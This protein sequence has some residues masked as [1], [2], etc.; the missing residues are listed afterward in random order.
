MPAAKRSRP[1]AKKPARRKRT[2]ADTRRRS[3]RRRWLLGGG[4][5]LLV[6]VAWLVWPFWQLSGQFAD[7]PSLQPSRLYA[8]A[9]LLRVGGPGS[10]RQLVA[11]L[12][13]LG[14][15]RSTD[16][17][18]EAGQ[19]DVGG[20]RVRTHLRAFPT[21]YGRNLGGPLEVRFS[22]RGVARL[23]W[24]GSDVQQVYL[25]P[26]LLA[27]Y[28]GPDRKE[29]RPA[30]L[31]ALPPHLV[32]AVLAAEDA[33]FYRHVGLS[34]RGIARAAWVNLR[35][36]ELR[37]GGSTLTQQLVKN[38]FL[39]HER[40]LARKLREIALALLVDL[41]YD[42]DAI[43]SA[44]LN[45]IYW[46]ASRSINLMGVGAAAWA[47][48]GK[49][50]RDLTV[51]ESAVLAGMI[52]SPGD[53]SPVTQPAA[54][55]ARRDWVLGRMAELEWLESSRLEEERARPLCV[56]PRYLGPR[57]AAYFADVAAGEARQRFGVGGLADAGYVLLS[58][59]RGADQRAAEEAAA[60]GIE[61]LE[62]GWEKGRE[63]SGPLQAA[64]VSIDPTSGGIRAYVGGRDY[65]ASQ[66]DRASR[67][68]RQAGSA[69]KPLVYAA[70][71]EHGVATPGTLL[72]D[73]P[74]TVA[75]AGDDWTPRNSD[76]GF[77]GW[78]TARTAVEESLN[79]P[80]A[81]LAL[82]VGL[83][84]V[85][86]LAHKLGIES[87]LRAV[88]ALA[89]GAFEVTPIELA[90]VYATLAAGGVRRPVHG[91]EAVL[92]PDGA[93]VEGRPLAAAERVLTPQTAYIVTSV[94]QGVLERGTGESARIQGVT[95][96]LAGKTGTTNDRRDSWFAGFSPDRTTLVWVGY[97]DNSSSRLSG[98]RAAL[99]IWGRFT[100]AVRPSNGYPRFVP[101]AGVS[102]A[103]IDPLSGQLATELCPRIQTEVF[104]E[105]QIPNS[106][107]YLH[108]GWARDQE[109]RHLREREIR[110]ERRR[111]RW[112]KRIFGRKRGG[113]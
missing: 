35:G 107:C 88:P 48:F 20:G 50:P 16:G 9:T 15:R 26:P 34:L 10:S 95:D 8:K 81:R 38:L 108:G 96:P 60:W 105:G 72:E 47:Y 3:L 77:R 53:F 49:D 30:R 65:G 111:P 90:S 33:G 57:F 13:D 59:V 64:L 63:G 54:S 109:W 103:V 62:K 18:L 39:T 93:P 86:A 74:L 5:V 14:Y 24:R 79:I 80:T 22:P 89:L 27:S 29:R 104:Y 69:F 25:E 52:P 6:A 12:E 112:F 82:R 71:F 11:E 87:S 102:T 58:T 31:A 61:A 42:K 100:W 28:Y 84:R 85:V 75:L 91:L 21:P 19:F 7:R 92:G 2:T 17:R 70:A 76:A 110:R 56:A 23:R 113:G 37:Q 67:A 106:L 36:G 101:P 51:C 46:G 32:H 73:A 78:V 66:F 55:R 4:V 1:R 43:L 98:A 97:D 99:P 41:R 44:Y 68:R 45:E 40:T 83:D 94:L